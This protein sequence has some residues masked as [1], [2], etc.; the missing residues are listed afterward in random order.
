VFAQISHQSTPGSSRDKF[1]D[2]I[3]IFSRSNFVLSREFFEAFSYDG[4]MLKF[5]QSAKLAEV[6]PAIASGSRRRALFALLPSDGQIISHLGAEPA[7]DS[8]AE[9]SRPA[10]GSRRFFPGSSRVRCP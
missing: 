3:G 4:A 7:R 6:T 2:C 5:G 9:P 8:A 10:D 1:P